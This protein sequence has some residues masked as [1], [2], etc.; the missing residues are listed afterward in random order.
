MGRGVG[1]DY[2][3]GGPSGGVGL[4][5]S[6]CFLCFSL[7]I[8]I[9]GTTK[10]KFKLLTK[11]T[12]LCCDTGCEWCTHLHAITVTRDLSSHFFKT[13]RFWRKMSSSSARAPGLGLAGMVS[14]WSWT[15]HSLNQ[16]PWK[17][18]DLVN[19]IFVIQQHGRDK[20]NHNKMPFE[21]RPKFSPIILKTEKRRKEETKGPRKAAL[22]SGPP[23]PHRP[24]SVRLL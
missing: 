16:L 17:R 7:L 10:T 2:E 6:D 21:N 22:F 18:S 12:Q 15:P 23:S 24:F 11:L 3:R 1:G 19:K 20:L 14:L 13:N 4:E 9:Q 8:K 5:F